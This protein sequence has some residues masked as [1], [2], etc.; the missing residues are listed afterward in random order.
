MGLMNA[1]LLREILRN[2]FWKGK[3]NLVHYSARAKFYWSH[4]QLMVSIINKVDI[5]V[6]VLLSVQY[7]GAALELDISQIVLDW[8]SSCVCVCLCAAHERWWGGSV[9]RGCS[10]K[11]HSLKED[12]QARRYL[13]LK[14]RPGTRKYKDAWKTRLWN[15]SNPVGSY[16]I[17]SERFWS[18]IFLL[19]IFC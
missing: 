17:I 12:M 6:H 14:I 10:A 16:W 5:G 19:C 7:A 13:N 8:S 11:K 9:Q 18:C 1:R 15:T 4:L 2:G 3:H